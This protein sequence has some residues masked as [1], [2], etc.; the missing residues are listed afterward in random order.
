MLKTLTGSLGT[1]AGV[2]K[3][4]SLRKKAQDN[5]NTAFVIVLIIV[6]TKEFLSMFMSIFAIIPIIGIMTLFLYSLLASSLVTIMLAIFFFGTGRK[7]KQFALKIIIL[8]LSFLFG[9]FIPFIPSQTIVVIWIW[10]TEITDYKEE[11][12]KAEEEGEN[13][14]KNSG[15]IN[16]GNI[17]LGKTVMSNLIN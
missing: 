17:K 14:I 10:I 9:I 11:Q 6:A 16:M 8:T 7:M 15:K 4:M 1:V 2:K 3:G 13:L 12:K 5:R